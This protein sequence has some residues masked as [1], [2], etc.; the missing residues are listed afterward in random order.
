M[1]DVVVHCY[2]GHTYAQEPHS[3]VWQ[4]R[5]YSVVSLEGVRRVLDN[6]TGTMVVEFIVETDAHTRFRL[7]Y[8]EGDDSWTIDQVA[9]W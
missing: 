9:G 7:C 8:N 3:F 4:G 2:S 6:V 5:E 1:T